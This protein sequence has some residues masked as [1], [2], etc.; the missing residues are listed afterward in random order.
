MTRRNGRRSFPPLATRAHGPST[1][2]GHLQPPGSPLNPQRA[3]FGAESRG[4]GSCRCRTSRTSGT[5]R[6]PPT[7]TRKRVKGQSPGAHQ[8]PLRRDGDEDLATGWGG[9]NKRSGTRMITDRLPRIRSLSGLAWR[10]IPCV[11]TSRRPRLRL[12]TSES[13]S[14]MDQTL[15][16][17]VG[18]RTNPGLRGPLPT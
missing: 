16:D 1:G 9:T 6:F 14:E 18:A 11:G 17:P 5:S 13:E 8:A 12:R 3:P 10:W 15:S 7:P 4:R 2:N